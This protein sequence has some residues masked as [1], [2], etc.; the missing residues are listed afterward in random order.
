[1]FLFVFGA[2]LVIQFLCMLLHR[3]LTLIHLL[4]R[5]PY[6]CGQAY[7]TFWAFRDDDT[8]FRDIND[9]KDFEAIIQVKQDEK[10]ARKRNRQAFKPK[11]IRHRKPEASPLIGEEEVY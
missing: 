10:I 4:G 2:I 3:L 5:A 9:E 8:M 1:M 7:H 6:R 11:S